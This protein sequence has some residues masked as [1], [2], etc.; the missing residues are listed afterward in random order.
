MSSRPERA[1]FFLRSFFERR[2]E[3]WR[4]RSTISNLS[5]PLGPNYIP[6]NHV[7]EFALCSGR[8]LSR[9]F[10]VSRRHLALPSGRCATHPVGQ[11]FELDSRSDEVRKAWEK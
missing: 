6:R 11:A 10:F 7:F 9:A 4:D 5:R 2:P 3:Q 8:G 1:G